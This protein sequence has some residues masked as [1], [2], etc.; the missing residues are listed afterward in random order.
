MTAIPLATGDY[1]RT[2]SGEPPM[3]LQNRYYE[4]DPSLST[5]QVA[6]IARPGLKQFKQVGNG[7]IRAIY[8]CPGSFNDAVFVISGDSLYRIDSDTN[9]TFIGA[10]FF[11]ADD[12]LFVSMTGTGNIGDTV[13]A[14]LFLADGRNLWLYV[15]NGFA[16]GVLTGTPANNDV[17]RVNNVYYK[18]TSGSVDAGTH[19]GTSGNPY[20]VA[21]GA[22]PVYAF[23]NLRFAINASGGVP[24][25]DYSTNTVANGLIKAIASDSSNITVQATGIGATG[26]GL[27]LTETGAGL[28]WN[29]ATTTGG[30]SPSLSIVETPD[31][32]AMISVCTSASYVVCVPAQGQNIN[33]QFYYIKPGETTIDPLDFATAESAPDPIYQAIAVGD[34]F[35]LPGQSTTEVWYF[36]TNP[37]APVQRLQGVSFNRGTWEGTAVQINNNLIIV[38]SNGGVFKTVGGIDRISDPSIEERIRYAMADQAAFF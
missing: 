3:I 28:A 36:T 37:E 11:G 27:P 38:D 34:Q 32:V 16:K 1:R 6:L 8:S 10:G 20:L 4:A 26:N 31:D 5:S 22:G 35:W 18:F 17:V 12:K 29:N 13:P 25:T 23:D 7:A 24:G 33:G 15:E 19:D 30:G 2:V 14:F 9:A 21:L